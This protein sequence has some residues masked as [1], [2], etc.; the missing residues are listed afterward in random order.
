MGDHDCTV[1]QGAPIKTAPLCKVCFTIIVDC[2]LLFQVESGLVIK[3]FM[4]KA[5]AKTFFTAK[6]K[7]RKLFQGQLQ[8]RANTDKI[9]KRNSKC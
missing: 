8:G 4:S 9:V 7:D 6:T 3:D 1:I 5:K 2:D